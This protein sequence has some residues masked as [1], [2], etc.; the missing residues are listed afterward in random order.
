MNTNAQNSSEKA[1]SGKTKRTP[2]LLHGKSICVRV[3]FAD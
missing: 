2:T 3:R 1:D